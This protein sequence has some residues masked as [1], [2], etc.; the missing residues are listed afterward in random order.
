[1]AKRRLFLRYGYRGVKSKER[2]IEPGEY[3]WDDPALFGLANYL[4]LTEHAAEIELP[5]ALPFSVEAESVDVVNMDFVQDP[6]A[7]GLSV[8][9]PPPTKPKPKRSRSRTR[10]RKED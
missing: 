9:E 6:E 1:M 10:K 2:F 5:E 4:I 3:E 8:T 7:V